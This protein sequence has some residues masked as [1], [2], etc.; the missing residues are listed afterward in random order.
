VNIVRKKIWGKL[1]PNQ[2]RKDFFMAG[3]KHYSA[4]EIGEWSYG[5]PVVLYANE[6]ATLKVGRF[7]SF[8]RNVTILLGGEHNIDWVTTYPFSAILDEAKA[9]PG[10]PLTRGDVTIGNDVWV[11]R[12]SLIMSGITIGD[13]AV[14][15]AA[16]I[17]RQNVAPYSIVG[18]NPARH[19]RFRFSPEQ[20]E[21]LQRIAWWN[22]PIERVIE[23]LPLLL[24][25]N[26][27][28]FVSKYDSSQ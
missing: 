4:F 21:S 5:S 3:N 22:W 19:L 14:I 25:P 6:K 2:R 10:H 11:A 9:F 23:A 20:I 28:D 26:I 13:G 16:S 15:G 27:Q 7:C 18:G 1:F 24:G 12:D 8:A 17:I